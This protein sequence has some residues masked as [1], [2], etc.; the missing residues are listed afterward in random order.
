MA[1]QVFLLQASF[2]KGQEELFPSIQ[3]VLV[4]YSKQLITI[5]SKAPLLYQ[6]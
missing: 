2:E 1:T 3:I 5:E 4:Q 6:I